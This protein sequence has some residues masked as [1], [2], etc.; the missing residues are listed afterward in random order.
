MR[1]SS[2][3]ISSVTI[4]KRVAKI[5]DPYYSDKSKEIDAYGATQLPA[6]HVV[7]A[8]PDIGQ[9]VTLQTHD[10]LPSAF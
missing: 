2:S 1:V 3:D 10:A 5:R 7:P 9:G 8:H 6:V 4:K